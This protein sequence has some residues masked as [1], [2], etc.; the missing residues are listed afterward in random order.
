LERVVRPHSSQPRLAFRLPLDATR[1]LRGRHRITD[2][3]HEHGVG[4][5]AVADV[6]LAIEEAMTNAVRHSGAKD[7]VEVRVGFEGRDLHATVRDH[8]AGFDPAAFDFTAVPDVLQSGGRGLYLM[9]RLMDGL[10]LIADAGLEVRLIKRGVLPDAARPTAPLSAISDGV[11]LGRASG[12]RESR[13]RSLIEEIPEG[14]AALDWEYHVIYA[15]DRALELYGLAREGVLGATLWALFPGLDDTELGRTFRDAMELGR[16]AILE[17][18]SPTIGRALEFRVYPTSS[19]VSF[20]IRDI[21]DRKRKERERDEYLEALLDS[22]DRFRSLFESMTEGVALHELIYEAGRA[23]D[24]YIVDVNRAFE[25]QSGLSARA[26]RGQRAST[27]Y[28]GGAPPYLDCYAGVATSGEAASFEAYFAPLERHFRITAISL[29]GGRFATVF[30]DI[31]E[32]KR[33]EKEREALVAALTESE[34]SFATIFEESPFAIS[35]TKMPEATTARVNRAFEE[36]FGY[37]RAE[38]IGR[39]SPDL[40]ISDPGSQVQLRERLAASGSVRDFECVRT[41]KSGARYVLSL[42]VDWVTVGPQRY[43]LT[44]IRDVTGQKQ[45]EHELLRSQAEVAR[46]EEQA[47]HLIRFAPAAIYEID[48]R[49][50]RLVSVNDYMCD[51]SGYSREELLA[52]DPF[53]VLDPEGRGPFLDRIARALVGDDVEAAAEYGVR[54]KHGELRRAVFNVTP[55][56]ED[57]RPVGAFVVAHDVT[58]LARTA[59]EREDLL[60][61]VER[62]LASTRVLSRT[63]I[64]ASGSLSIE[65]V[66]ERVLAAIRDDLG[67]L[68]AGSIHLID[69]RAAKLRHLALFGYPQDV[70]HELRELPLSPASNVGRVALNGLL[71]TH[72]SGEEPEESVGRRDLMGLNDARWLAAPVE[73]AGELLGVM[74]LFFNGKRAFRADELSLY[75]GVAA[76]LGTAMANARLYEQQQRIAT[77]LQENFLHPLPSVQGLELAV[78]SLPANRPELVGGDFS[79]VFVLPD[80]Q[81]AVLIGDVAGKGVQAAGLTETVRSTIRAFATMDAS[82]AFIL[83][84]T[85]ELLLRY[86][87]DEPHV[88]AFLFVLDPATGQVA[89]ASAG[90][91]APVHLSPYAGRALDVPFGPP[92]GTFPTEYEATHLTLTPDDYLVLYTD[93]VT[94]ARRDGQMLGERRL[95][96]IVQGLRGLP[97]EEVAQGVADAVLAYGGRLRDDLQVVVVRLA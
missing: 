13:E 25:R 24:Y 92:L 10:E 22:E 79:D 15:N 73:R 21:D 60:A 87:P 32:R 90:H 38:L 65:G 78:R 14:F 81:V 4:E 54:T 16:P 91:P 63:A 17:Y 68:R 71:V 66:A 77:I 85:N 2:Y 93:G 37:T 44:T 12:Y 82:P 95:V 11:S 53:D 96:Q 28:G 19:G 94:E 35:L 59:A 62:E 69:R 55:H 42:N 9:A 51:F 1:L 70:A 18:D 7:G 20:Y 52:M 86:D 5:A 61:R 72:E 40:G 45:A 30:D 34:Q 27:A 56:F 67:E 74:A 84:R 23:V 8:G 58:E 31:S 36:L 83:G 46:Q 43:V 47:R 97:A 48:L 39:T 49:G 89:A 3:L 29:D 75:Q 76:I 50:P 6:V 41:A 80:G 26:V 57:G 88:T 33:V 64:T